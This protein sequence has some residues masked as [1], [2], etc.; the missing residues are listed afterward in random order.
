MPSPLC[1]RGETETGQQGSNSDAEDD[2][3]RAGAIALPVATQKNAYALVLQRR[4]SALQESIKSL[5][6]SVSASVDQTSTE[7]T[8]RHHEGKTTIIVWYSRK[9]ALKKCRASM[10]ISRKNLT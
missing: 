2:A 7:Q 8:H 6:G 9:T 4:V 10:Y 1:A 3:G 5:T